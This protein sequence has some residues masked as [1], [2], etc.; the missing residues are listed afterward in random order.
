M[1]L[2]LTVVNVCRLSSS[3]LPL[4]K[5][6]TIPIAALPRCRVYLIEISLTAILFIER[7]V[8]AS[9]SSHIIKRTNSLIIERLSPRE[10]LGRHSAL[11]R[12]DFNGSQ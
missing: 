6:N 4:E 2:S 3:F 9:L 12:G 1:H 5:R 8:P 10:S 11:C 7:C